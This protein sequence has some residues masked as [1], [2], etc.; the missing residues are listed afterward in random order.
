MSTPILVIGIVALAFSVWALGLWIGRG[1]VARAIHCVERNIDVDLQV[2]TR[3]DAHWAPAAACDV[4]ECS[5]FDD[6]EAV[7]CDKA[8][9][10][11]AGWG[12]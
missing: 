7:T 5:A 9:L 2:R 8:C 4:V 1:S 10:R 6:P 3:L 11:S 12:I